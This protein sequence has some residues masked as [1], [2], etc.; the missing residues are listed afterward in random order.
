[1]NDQPIHFAGLTAAPPPPPSHPAPPSPSSTPPAPPHHLPSPAPYF[2][3]APTLKLPPGLSGDPPPPPP[4][5]SSPPPPLGF[6][7]AAPAVQ[8]EDS[9]NEARAPEEAAEDANVISAAPQIRQNDV[10]D[11]NARRCFRCFLDALIRPSQ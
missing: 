8:D 2:P 7:P 6:A 10:E 1:M 4:P 11:G 3:D 9:Q 5:T